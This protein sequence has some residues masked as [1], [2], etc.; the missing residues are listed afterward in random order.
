MEF[1]VHVIILEY[2]E[3]NFLIEFDD[4]IMSHTDLF[5]AGVFDSFGYLKLIAFLKEEFEIEFST[6]GI[7][8][9]LVSSLDGIVHLVDSR[10]KSQSANN[11]VGEIYE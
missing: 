5:R 1:Y 8:T 4:Q 6:E 3:K 10:L 2:I 11:I 7:L 9:D